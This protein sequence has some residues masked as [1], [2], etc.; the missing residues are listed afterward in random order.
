MLIADAFRIC[1]LISR[2]RSV[3]TWPSVI[4]R[5]VRRA[6]N[7]LSRVFVNIKTLIKRTKNTIIEM[8]TIFLVS[9]RMSFID[10]IPQAFLQMVFLGLLEVLP[11]LQAQQLRVLQAYPQVVLRE[12][13]QL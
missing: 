12:N 11:R 13:S 7:I 8:R 6:P 1:P 10:Q 2:K 5:T 4:L 3:T 9:Y